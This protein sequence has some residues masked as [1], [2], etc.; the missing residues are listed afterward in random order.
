MNDANG[1]AD[2]PGRSPSTSWRAL[3]ISAA[4]AAGT[5]LLTVGIAVHFL[6]SV[7][8]GHEAVGRLGVELVRLLL[9]KLLSWPAV[10]IFACVW[11]RRPI[12]RWG[13]F[14]VRVAAMRP[15]KFGGVVELPPTPHEGQS[16]LA[17]DRFRTEKS[18]GG[19]D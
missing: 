7:S 18:D 1:A 3:L 9:D 15:W 13:E 8:S 2:D 4:V 17:T 11:L 19:N 6:F 16:P 14:L 12:L 10:A 5:S